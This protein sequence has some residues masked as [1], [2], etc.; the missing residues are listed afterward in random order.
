MAQLERNANVSAAII[1]IILL[2]RSLLIGDDNCDN[3]FLTPIFCLFLAALYV[4]RY[5]Q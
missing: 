2:P 4:K 3:T 1:I 5:L